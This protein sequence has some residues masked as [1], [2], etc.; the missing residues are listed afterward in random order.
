MS[1]LGKAQKALEAL[2]NLTRAADWNEAAIRIKLKLA[3]HHFVLHAI[4]LA[5]AGLITIPPAAAADPPVV[6]GDPDAPNAPYALP[7]NVDRR[8]AEWDQSKVLLQ[9]DSLAASMAQLEQKWAGQQTPPTLEVFLPAGKTKGCSFNMKEGGL[10]RVRTGWISPGTELRIYGHPNGSTL[11][12]AQD[13]TL[14]IQPSGLWRGNMRLFDLAIEGSKRNS[15]L[16]GVEGLAPAPLERIGLIDCKF[17]D[18]PGIKTVRI[19][20]RYQSNFYYVRCLIDSPNSVEHFDYDRG[21]HL[22]QLFLDC[23]CRAVGGQFEKETMR[24]KN[25]ESPYLPADTTYLIGNKIAGCHLETNADL[26]RGGKVIENTDTGRHCIIEGNDFEALDRDGIDPFGAL[27]F[28]AGRKGEPSYS[29]RFAGGFAIGDVRIEGNTFRWAASGH[30]LG[31]IQVAKSAEI[32]ENQFESEN[33]RAIEIDCEELGSVGGGS[34]ED[35]IGTAQLKHR[36]VTKPINST[37]QF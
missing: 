34:F 14:V 24:P 4:Q 21:P 17:I 11:A 33:A 23:D 12:A 5:D 31:S 36:L 9:P 6:V 29:D 28:W 25:D 16:A 2:E 27:T 19:V 35:N 18:A 30:A 22:W 8:Q 7:V 37:I 20:S 32:F 10:T 15:I 13:R 26:Q 3:S 1:H